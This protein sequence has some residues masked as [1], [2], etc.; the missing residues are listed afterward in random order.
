[1]P[2]FNHEFFKTLINLRVHSFET[3]EVRYVYP[4]SE[5]PIYLSKRSKFVTN[6]PISFIF[7]YFHVTCHVTIIKRSGT[8][9]PQDLL[10]NKFHFVGLLARGIANQSSGPNTPLTQALSPFSFFRNRR[11]ENKDLDC[12]STGDP[13]SRYE[14]RV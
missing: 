14:E 11:G 10:L 3:W 4:L 12:S 5:M 13:N 1:M 7:L 9:R 8:R 2:K 6:S